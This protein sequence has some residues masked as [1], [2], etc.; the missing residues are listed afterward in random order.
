M[1]IQSLDAEEL[2]RFLAVAKQERERDWL[3]FL[4]AFSHGLRV[5]EVITLKRDAVHDGRI[6]VQRLKGS[7]R[8]IQPL[9]AS[10]DSLFNEAGALP[11]WALKSPPN[12]P[13][14]NMTRQHAWRLF[15]RYGELAGIPEHKRHPHVLKHTIAMQTIHSAGI[16]NVRQYLGHKSISSTG[17]YLQVSDEQAAQAIKKSLTD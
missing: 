16:E 13:L 7:K 12:Q 6:S 5:S 10:Q 8:T 9:V 4:V 15:Q 1:S 2:R 3:M 14:F 17:S 11:A